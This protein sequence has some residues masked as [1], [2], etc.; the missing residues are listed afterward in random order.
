M[1]PSLLVFCA[2][3]VLLAASLF[4]ADP[5]WAWGGIVL[6]AAAAYSAPAGRF[7]V[8]SLSIGLTLFCAW[9]LANAALFTPHY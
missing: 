1:R 7:P 9:L 5:Y 6:L 3:V 2:A 4:P 8:N